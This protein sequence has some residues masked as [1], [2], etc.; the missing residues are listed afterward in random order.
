MWFHNIFLH[1]QTNIKAFSALFIVLGWDE[2]QLLLILH[3]KEFNESILL[4]ME[5]YTEDVALDFIAL[6]LC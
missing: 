2:Y 4:Q 1:I 3:L 5:L 6:H